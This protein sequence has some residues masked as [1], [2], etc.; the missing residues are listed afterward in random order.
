MET[1]LDFCPLLSVLLPVETVALFVLSLKGALFDSRPF[2]CHPLTLPVS[3]FAF[4]AVDFIAADSF[5]LSRLALNSPQLEDC[6][7][8]PSI[9]TVLF[10]VDRTVVR[11]PAETVWANEWLLWQEQFSK[12]PFSWE[13]SASMLWLLLRDK[14]LLTFEPPWNC[15]AE[16]SESGPLLGVSD[17]CLE[18][19][20]VEELDDT[21]HSV[22]GMCSVIP[23]GLIVAL[24]GPPL[25]LTVCDEVILC[26]YWVACPLSREVSEAGWMFLVRWWLLRG[27]VSC[28]GGMDSSFMK[29]WSR[30]WESF[31][32]CAGCWRIF[33][34]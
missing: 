27:G 12:S 16:I 19:V 30:I 9:P 13:F 6:F 28:V 33:Q 10:L 4:L 23:L 1:P 26:V 32:R 18:C 11:P 24:M 17:R 20:L 22:D 14:L 34:S 21:V 7:L 29:G 5:S 15:E 25:L 31:S 3:L 8:V 2:L